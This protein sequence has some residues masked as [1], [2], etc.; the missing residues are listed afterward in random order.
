MNNTAPWFIYTLTAS[1]GCFI[2]DLLSG[3]EFEWQ[4]ARTETA[5]H[6]VP[7][8]ANRYSHK[9]QTDETRKSDVVRSMKWFNVHVLDS[10]KFDY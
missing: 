1:D 6:D 2:F 10:L 4:V 9:P 7:F 3:E 8:Y 5:A